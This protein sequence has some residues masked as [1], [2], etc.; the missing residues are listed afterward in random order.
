LTVI[1]VLKICRILS[2]T[3]GHGTTETGLL[4]CFFAISLPL[5][6]HK[7]HLIC[8]P[9]HFRLHVVIGLSLSAG[10]F[11]TPITTHTGLNFSTKTRLRAQ[12]KHS[13][14]AIG[15]GIIRA[16]VLTIQNQLALAKA[17]ALGW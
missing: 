1:W 5:Y 6:G 4:L 13:Q 11:F 9:R 2:R 8:C 16:L 10:A 14:Q 12:K 3:T 7:R 17:H 15:T